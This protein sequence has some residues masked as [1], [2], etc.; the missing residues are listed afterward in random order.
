LRFSQKICAFRVEQ[1]PQYKGLKAAHI[2]ARKSTS[3]EKGIASLKGGQRGL[4]TGYTCANT[5][6]YNLGLYRR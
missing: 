5:S 3:L 4:G 1:F 6:L 2:P